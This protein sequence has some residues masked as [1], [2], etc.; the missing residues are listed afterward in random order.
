MSFGEKLT[1]LRKEKGMSQEELANE[2]NVSRQAVSKWE[3]NN[4]Y[5]ETEK[6]VSIC[7]L[8]NTSM[9]EL[10]GIKEKSPQINHKFLNIINNYIET[11]IRAI[12]M[13]YCMTFKQKIKCVIEMLFYFGIIAL[14]LFLVNW[15]IKI[16]IYNLLRMLPYYMLKIVI[17]TFQ[18][19]L[20]AVYFIIMV[21]CLFKLYKLRYLNYYEEA[22]P[23]VVTETYANASEKE[24]INIK[25]EKIIIRDSNNDISWLKKIFSIFIKI[26]AT[27]LAFPVALIFVFLIA[28]TIFILFFIH[29]GVILVYIVLGLVSISLG[30]YIVLESLIKVIFSIRIK[31]SKILI[32]T[33]VSLITFGVS[34]GLFAGEFSHFVF[35]DS[36]DYNYLIRSLNYKMKDNLIISYLDSYNTEIIFEERDNILVEFYGLDEDLLK[37][38]HEEM[39]PGDKIIY[40]YQI[41]NNY[42]G[43]SLSDKIN[44][45]LNC[46]KEKKIITNYY[47]IKIKIH[48]SKNNYNKLM[49]NMK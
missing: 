21:F 20:Y 40:G 6:I 26:M 27:C 10:I 38:Y 41:D 18:G 45:L 46:I 34:C 2:L 28:F 44:D 15:T 48:L 47:D 35:V 30:A 43:K 25:E 8:F 32:F 29:N 12:K 4:A 39:K 42:D 9:D 22:K 36:N 5:P 3:S 19:I 11:F 31:P 49:E 17:D 16:I 24:K 33:I 37:V 1:K 7:K 14:F 23:K 13:F